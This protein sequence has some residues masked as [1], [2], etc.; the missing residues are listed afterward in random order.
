MVMLSNADQQ[1]SLSI[2]IIPIG[3]FDFHLLG[4]AK[5]DF[6]SCSAPK[7]NVQVRFELCESLSCDI[8]VGQK[9]GEA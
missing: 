2:F 3:I 8:E 5:D 6:F 1:R 4:F 7:S 9:M